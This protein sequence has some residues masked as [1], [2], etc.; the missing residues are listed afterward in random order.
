[1]AIP[2]AWGDVWI[3]PQSNGHLQARGR[4]ESGRLQYIYHE[5]WQTISDGVKFDRLLRFAELLPRIR[6][7]VRNDLNET[8]L[9]KN[10]VLAA[11]VRL[12][13][14]TR[15]RI[16]NDRYAQ[17]RGTRGATTLGPEHVEVDKFTVSLDFPGKSK[18]R[19][20]LEFTNEKVAKVI[21]KCQ[22]I[23]G[24][25][26]FSYRTKD[27]DFDRIDSTDVNRYLEM[28]SGESVTAKDF[29]TWWG[30]V[31][32][33]AELS[34]FPNG[35]SAA[36]RKRLSVAAVDAAAEELGNTRAVC[37]QSYIHPGILAAAES[38]ELS[39]LIDKLGPIDTCNNEMTIDEIRFANLLPHLEFT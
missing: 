27:G 29:R 18:K 25:Y 15:V 14:K 12:L 8:S 35:L 39:T 1:M 38:G 13:D 26:L 24:E 4:D 30:S 21:Q 32:A 28:F 5:R 34:D 11:A 9:T 2:P 7:R 6:R 10:R 19:R 16:G 31:I 37:R 20:T 22:E 17:E 23:D 36:E 33:L 3:C